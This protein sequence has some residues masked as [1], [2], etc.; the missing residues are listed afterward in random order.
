MT[1]ILNTFYAHAP[2]CLLDNEL[3]RVEICRLS[4]GL[5]TKVVVFKR[6]RHESCRYQKGSSRKV[7]FCRELT[8]KC[9]D[10]I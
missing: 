10:D 2:F 9:R 1:D 7:S 8:E 6:A 3:F 5:V 4:R